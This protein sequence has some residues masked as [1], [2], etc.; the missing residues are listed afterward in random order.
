[1]RKPI[2][3]WI[4]KSC[5]PWKSSARAGSAI[6]FRPSLALRLQRICWH[7][8]NR[9]LG[10]RVRAASPDGRQRTEAQSARS[11]DVRSSGL[12][13][14]RQFLEQA[15]RRP[16]FRVSQRIGGLETQSNDPAP[17]ADNV[18]CCA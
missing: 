16:P 11:L 5:P 1:M 8:R 10:S 13:G 15:F 9:R 17:G 18:P 3:E 14:L 4:S 7:E 12:T 2:S 6:E